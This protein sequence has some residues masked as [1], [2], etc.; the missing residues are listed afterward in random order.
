MP[1]TGILCLA[2]VAV[3]LVNHTAADC[4]L[5]MPYQFCNKGNYGHP[6]GFLHAGIHV[7]LTPF[8]YLVLVPA[9]L[10]L[11]LG[12]ALGEFANHYH[13]DWAK[14]QVGRR[15]HARSQAACCWHAL[16]IDQLLH[17]LN[18]IGIVAVLMWAMR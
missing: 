12:I 11:V 10:R 1:E 5:Q 13:M 14:E 17:G 15:L 16:G 18:Y 6:S 7:V 4:F 2:A 8:V 9:S 3:L